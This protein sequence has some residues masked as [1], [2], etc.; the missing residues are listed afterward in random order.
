MREANCP[1]LLAAEREDRRRMSPVIL[2]HQP[3]ASF[4]YSASLSLYQP[5]NA[6]IPK[7]SLA[8]TAIGRY[9]SGNPR[10][11][12]PGRDRFKLF[13]ERKFEFITA[14]QVGRQTAIATHQN[15]KPSP[16]VRVYLVVELLSLAPQP[17]RLEH[18]IFKG[19]PSL[20]EC[21]LR[22]LYPPH[23]FCR[24]SRS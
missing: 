7:T 18:H 17:A 14:P 10:S 20:H 9:F 3:K 6:S 5:F 22:I 23:E 16:S 2:F 21:P 24:G 15:G 19:A 12:G 8:A 13:L 1:P 11:L 4:S